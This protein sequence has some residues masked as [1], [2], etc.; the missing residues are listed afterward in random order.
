MES[1]ELKQIWK[2]S[3]KNSKIYT[4]KEI[5]NFQ[6]RKQKNIY[7]SL[8]IHIWMNL[9]TKAISCFGLIALLSYSSQRNI[10]I[11]NLSLVMIAMLLC[12]TDLYFLKKIAN[13]RV[14][15]DDLISNL[16]R[17]QKTLK[18]DFP[19]YK[20][21]ASISVPMLSFVAIQYFSTIKY[22]FF[23][24]VDKEDFIVIC[25]ILVLGYLISLL[26][27][28]IISREILKEIEGSFMEF[29][30]KVDS[31]T[32]INIETRRKKRMKLVFITISLIGIIALLLIILL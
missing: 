27:G 6:Y 17:I 5:A 25:I 18:S 10:F 15:S 8:Q 23:K 2:S 1:T 4:S 12:G 32:L 31:N 20:L 28:T 7:K 29:E 21:V 19:I 11:L 24:M 13:I 30:N 22:G 16:A 3:Q 9:I 26:G 14:P